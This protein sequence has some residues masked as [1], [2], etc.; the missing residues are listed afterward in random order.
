MQ[1]LVI[2]FQN[3]GV[4]NK[5]NGDSGRREARGHGQKR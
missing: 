2:A 4:G 3:S 5:G 1:V